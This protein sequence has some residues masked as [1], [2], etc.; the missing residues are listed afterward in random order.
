MNSIQISKF[1][2]TPSQHAIF[3]M[4]SPQTRAITVGSILGDTFVPGRLYS[5]ALR[6]KDTYE[7]TVQSLQIPQIREILNRY[8]PED[9]STITVLRE[10]LACR[11]ST[12]LSDVGIKNHYGDAFIGAT[13]VKGNGEITTS[14]LYENIE[15]LTPDGLWIIADSICVGRNLIATMKSLLAKFT[16]KEVLFICPIA[17]RVGI[18]AVDALLSAKQISTTYVAWGALFGVDEKTLYD[19]PWGHPNTEPLDKRDQQ[20]FISM[21]GPDLCVGGDFGNY[22]YCPPLA[23]KLYDEQLTLHHIIPKIPTK[24]EVQKIYAEDEILTR[25]A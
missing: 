7:A 19:M 18:T 5:G 21:Y 4:Q 2:S 12:A 22:Y 13:H 10:T 15:G 25:R 14:Y 6:E 20:T 17:S 3:V 9:V 1:S 8:A 23:K 24:E 16:P 11:L